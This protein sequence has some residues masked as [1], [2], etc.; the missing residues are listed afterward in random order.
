MTEIPRGINSAETPSAQNPW[1]EIYSLKPEKKSGERLTWQEIRARKE[2]ITEAAFE[3]TL[4]KEKLA[5][6]S[7]PE[8]RDKDSFREEK[9]QKQEL[10]ECLERIKKLPEHLKFDP[11]I[12]IIIG[13]NGLGKST[14]ARALFMAMQ[15]QEKIEDGEDPA[16][17]ERLIFSRPKKANSIMQEDWLG[18]VPEIGKTVKVDVLKDGTVGVGAGTYYDATPLTGLNISAGYMRDSFF[19]DRYFRSHRQTIDFAFGELTRVKKSGQNPGIYFI[20]EPETGMD[21]KRHKGIVKE[22]EELTIKNSIMIIPTNSTVLFDSD[23]P[24]IDLD[25]PERGIHRP[26]QYPIDN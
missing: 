12:T 14:L 16:M 11:G 2:K 23:L 8:G 3:V 6:I 18:L 24:R 4:D 1:A 15:Y 22:I 25:N 10:E 19:H 13:R 7:I 17:A 5:E 21:P 26:S 9:S 20:D